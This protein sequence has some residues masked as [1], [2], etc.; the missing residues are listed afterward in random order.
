MLP[1]AAAVAGGRNG[2]GGGE[3]RTFSSFMRVVAGGNG[4]F[5]LCLIL[6]AFLLKGQAA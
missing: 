3:V 2:G 1:T 4:H 6:C 5:I